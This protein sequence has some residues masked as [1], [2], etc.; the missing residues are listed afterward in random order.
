MTYMK[1]ASST[2]PVLWSLYEAIQQAQSSLM[3]A[4]SMLAST[5]L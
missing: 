1:K 2:V 5:Q 4:Q 3:I